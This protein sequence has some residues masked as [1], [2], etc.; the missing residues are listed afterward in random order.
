MTPDTL[1][2]PNYSVVLPRDMKTKREGSAEIMEPTIQKRH[3]DTERGL[4][5]LNIVQHKI[6]FSI[7]PIQRM[8]RIIIVSDKY[9]RYCVS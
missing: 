5:A 3:K 7:I 2:L 4:S 6:S 8:E 9:N 1:V